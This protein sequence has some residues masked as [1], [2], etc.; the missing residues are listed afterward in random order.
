[1]KEKNGLGRWGP[2]WWS[3]AWRLL[4][5]GQYVRP[6]SLAEQIARAQE[7]AGSRSPGTLP[8]STC[9]ARDGI[10]QV[11]VPPETLASLG[12]PA[13]GSEPIE[14]QFAFNSRM[15]P[16]YIK[17]HLLLDT[18]QGTLAPIFSSFGAA[19]ATGSGVGQQASGP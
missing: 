18:A 9:F 15:L 4:V 6:G 3:G 10:L 5:H 13:G 8:R 11:V 1:M 14:M 16:L 2:Y 7:E 12:P 17:S 19:V